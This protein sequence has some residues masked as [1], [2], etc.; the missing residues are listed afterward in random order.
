MEN[1]KYI[2]LVDLRE[3]NGKILVISDDEGDGVAQF[4]FLEDAIKCVEQQPLCQNY[5]YVI[6][7]MD[8]QEVVYCG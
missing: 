2:I 4:E 3:N 1:E 8:S 6:I 7:D 5:P